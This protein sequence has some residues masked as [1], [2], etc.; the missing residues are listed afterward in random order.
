LSAD[1]P[2]LLALPVVPVADPVA[3]APVLALLDA[4]DEDT[5]V[6]M[7]PPRFD[8]ELLDGAPVVADPDVPVAVA[9][10][11]RQPVT[12]IVCA[13]ADR[14]SADPACPVVGVCPPDCADAATASA[15]EN[16]VP[17]IK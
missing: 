13:E 12:V 3:P 14:L 7:K 4:P 11:R 2:L 9:P 15:A 8:E 6:R 16:T 17:N 10:E 5:S 1:A